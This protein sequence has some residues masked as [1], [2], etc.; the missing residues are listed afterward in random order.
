MALV[1]ESRGQRDLGDRIT[2]EQQVLGPLDPRVDLIGVRRHPEVGGEAAHQVLLADLRQ[3]G[4]LVERDGG[5]EVLV[6]EAARSRV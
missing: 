3:R 6:E 5:G 2:A 4:E 1:V